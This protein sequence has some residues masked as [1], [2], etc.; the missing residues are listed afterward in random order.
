[1]HGILHLWGLDAAEPENQVERDVTASSLGLC[2]GM[3]HLVQS[4]V[5]M[6]GSRR[7]SL[8]QVTRHA[9]CVDGTEPLL[10]GLSQAPLWGMA[11]VIAAEHPELNCVRIDI[12]PGAGCAGP[13]LDEI[14]HG[15]REDRIA[16]RG[17]ARYSAKLTPFRNQG[18]GGRGEE[19]GNENLPPCPLPPPIIRPDSAYLISGGLGGTGL[20]MAR[21]LAALGAGQIILF[22]RGGKPAD[23]SPASEAIRQL[24]RSGTRIVVLQ[25]DVSQ[26]GDVEAVLNSIRASGMPLKGIIHAAGVFADRMLTDH[27]EALFKTVFA[28]KVTG[29]WNLHELTQ[30]IPLDFFVLFS[31]ATAF[32]CSAGLGNYVAANAFL[33]ALAHY[34]RHMGLPGLSIDWGPWTGTGMAEAVDKRRAEKSLN[35]W[36]A[37]GLDTL[38]PETALSVF[39]RLLG[40]TDPQVIAMPMDWKRFFGQLP[41]TAR[42]DF[43]DRISHREAAPGPK[44]ENFFAKLTAAPA[45]QWR[46]LLSAHI[47]SLVADVLGLDSAAAIDIRQG[48]FQMGMD[49]LTSMELRNRLQKEFARPLSA[50]LIFKFPTVESLADHLHSTLVDPARDSIV[51]SREKTI[52]RTGGGKQKMDMTDPDALSE[53]E[54]EALLIETLEKL[55]Y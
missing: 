16:L 47:R 42:P 21:R 35:Q 31:S 46:N 45:D 34:R 38:A 43:F 51:E 4:L 24:E 28:A 30:D 23:G 18:A 40:A 55:G 8:W 22:G 54:A 29:A 44:G 52:G 41:P 26:R 19:A 53:K 3:L 10:S 48:F 13:L 1:L 15:H 32:V 14:L 20:L 50:T 2:M 37:G 27:E 25:A 12:D 39:H 7:P 6:E 17:D 33:D 11:Q 5:E 36:A 9:V 49:S